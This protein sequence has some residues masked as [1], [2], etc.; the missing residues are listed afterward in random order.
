MNFNEEA[1]IEAC[2]AWIKL[3]EIIGFETRKDAFLQGYY[4]AH[5]KLSARNK[6]L[7][8]VCAAA[9]DSIPQMICTCNGEMLCERC[10]M[11]DALKALTDCEEE[12]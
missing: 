10:T 12:V 3:S 4:I 6:K 5:N 9:K 8:A 7:E 1:W 2:R 11:Y